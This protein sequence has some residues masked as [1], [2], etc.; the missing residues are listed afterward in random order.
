MILFTALL[1]AQEPPAETGETEAQELFEDLLVPEED[2]DVAGD[3]DRDLRAGEPGAG[4]PEAGEPGEDNPEAD[5]PDEVIEDVV[6]DLILNEVIEDI[7][8]LIQGHSLQFFRGNQLFVP[9]TALS[10]SQ[11]YENK[12]SIPT[13]LPV[14]N[15][16]F[17]SQLWV[18]QETVTLS[19]ELS[20]EGE[21]VF[22][23]QQME[24]LLP[25]LPPTLEYRES[26]LFDI[27]TAK[28][29]L[30]YA[31]ESPS[32]K[33]HAL[34]IEISAFEK[35]PPA[36][37]STLPGG[38]LL[39]WP[40]P[41][42]VSQPEEAQTSRILI[43][44][45]FDQNKEPVEI[46]RY[47][48]DSA[49]RFYELQ[50]IS[51]GRDMRFVSLDEGDMGFR[52]LILNADWS[53]LS[54]RRF[55]DLGRLRYVNTSADSSITQSNT[56]IQHFDNGEKEEIETFQAGGEE[57]RRYDEENNLLHSLRIFADGREE[58]RRFSY[59]EE[60]DILSEEYRGTLGS[61]LTKY[62][63]EGEDLRVVETREDG[64]ITRRIENDGDESVETRYVRGRAVLRIYLENDK[65]VREEELFN[66]EVLRRREYIEEG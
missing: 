37:R 48:Y 5:A 41:E 7:N 38:P 30:L 47:R 18:N 8:R 63:Y 6:I 50:R 65:R 61:V 62:R 4:T 35:R 34:R 23:L 19:P 57:Q 58:E 15:Q 25:S 10:D 54:L 17:L 16:P 28:I 33:L 46:L 13:S 2:S 64:V 55:D 66:G 21:E 51:E 31:Y 27:F 59:T 22:L 32:L 12:L 44:L 24:A 26:A 3:D 45:A 56:R 1:F 36:E 14:P 43:R 29:S 40:Q 53:V 60:G 11:F 20:L 42:E 49:G 9:G 39:L 52:E